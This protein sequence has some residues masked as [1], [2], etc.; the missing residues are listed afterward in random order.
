[1]TYHDGALGG[2]S[3]ISVAVVPMNSGRITCMLL[4][5]PS[6]GL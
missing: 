5:T 6:R 3:R 4:Y 1:M 2:V